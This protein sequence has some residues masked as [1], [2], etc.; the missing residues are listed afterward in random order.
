[1]TYTVTQLITE[2]YYLS[3]RV[4]QSL[5]TITGYQLNAGL[6]YLNALL[7]VKTV[8]ERLIPYFTEYQFDAVVGQES[9]FI[10]NLV[11]AET[12]TFLYSTVRWSMVQCTRKE[13]Q[14][15]SRAENINSIMQNYYVERCLGGANLFMYFFPDMTYPM[16]I[17]GKFSLQSVVLNQDLSTTLDAFYLE[18]LR[19]ALGEYICQANNIT[20]QP[21]NKKTLDDFEQQFLDISAP[22]L[23]VQNRTRYSGM[24]MWS[25][26]MLNLGHGWTP[27]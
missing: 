23:T 8:N 18:Y 2:S 21:Q 19:Y 5:Q 13:Y 25:W 4:S 24:Q 26:G 10:P 16:K 1:M 27:Q 11:F 22:D 7:A 14:G 15:S 12:L 20:F 9:Y 6:R 3:G 17:V